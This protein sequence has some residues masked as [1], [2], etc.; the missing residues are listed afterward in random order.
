MRTPCALSREKSERTRNGWFE[1]EKR[2]AFK[3]FLRPPMFRAVRRGQPALRRLAQRFLSL[4][5]QINSWIGF[6]V[7]SLSALAILTGRPD[8]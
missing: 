4:Q 3:E 6:P 8:G 7:R 5:P 2:V 1:E